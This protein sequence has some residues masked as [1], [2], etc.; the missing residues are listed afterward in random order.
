MLPTICPSLFFSWL[1][2]SNRTR[3]WFAIPIFQLSLSLL[4]LLP[5]AGVALAQA[6]PTAGV[7]MFST[8]MDGV[9]LAT[10]NINI[11][12]PLLSKIGKIPFSSALT[13]TSGIVPFSNG[14]S[15][16][17]HPMLSDSNNFHLG[18]PAA[19]YPSAGGTY[20][21]IEEHDPPVNCTNN[22]ALQ[23]YEVTGISVVDPGLTTHGIAGPLFETGGCNQTPSAGPWSADDGS[24]YTVTVTNGLPT[25]YDKFG[26]YTVTTSCSIAKSAPYCVGTTISDPDGASISATASSAFT[27][28]DTL[29][30]TAATYTLGSNGIAS[31]YYTADNNT[32][33]YTFSYTTINAYT[34]FGCPAINDIVSGTYSLLTGITTP[35]GATYSF[36][37]EQTPGQGSGYTTGRIAKITF[38]AG[39][40]ISYGYSQGSDTNGSNGMDCT[41]YVVPKLIVTVN[42]N[43]GNSGVWTYVNTDTTKTPG[44]YTVTETDPAGNQTTY[45][46]SGEYQT[47]AIYYQGTS[48]VLK[49]VLTCYNGNTSNCAAP[50]TAV[51]LPIT[52]TDVRTTLG[53]SAA[54][55]LTTTFDSYG[56]TLV[57]SAYDFG[58]TL[59]SPSGTLLSTTT[60]VY[61]QS[62]SSPTAC[63]AYPSG[64]YI[65]NTPCYSYTTN[66]AGTKV[67]QTKIAY[68]PTGH[69]TQVQKWTSGSN[70]LTSSATYNTT[71]GT[72]ATATDVNGTVSTYSYSGSGGCENSLLPTSVTVTG[73]NLPSAGLTTSAQWNC[74]G[75]VPIQTTDANG[76]NTTYTYNDPLWRVK[77][78]TD[79]LGFLTTYNY[80]PTT[81]E[82][83]MN[84]N[85]G[86]STTE[87]L[88]T[89]DGLGRPIYSQTLQAPGSL[90]YDSTQ[91]TYSWTTKTGSLCT[92]AGLCTTVSMSYVGTAGQAAPSGTPVTTTQNDALGRPV[93]ITD[94]GGGTV[95]YV[96]PF[97]D[98]WESVGPGQNFAKQFQYDSMGRLSSVC[99]IISASGSGYG[100]CGQ[101]NAENGFLTTYAYDALGDLTNVNQNMQS[102]AVNGQ[103]SRTYVYDGL[104][105]LT[106]ETN[107]ETGT[108]SYIYDSYPSGTCGG[109]TSEPGE[110][111]VS[112][113]AN[114]DWSCMWTTVCIG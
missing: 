74:N 105:R 93:T 29:G 44:N 37:Y 103:Q 109:W 85:D 36:S 114:G 101:S 14:S 65:Y 16:Y 63:N 31:F 84:F 48:T 25:I 81:F 106:S 30:T 76:N 1:F 60:N 3:D 57:V 79:P 56:N 8:N 97:N 26:N 102:G 2:S 110:L 42:D 64:T 55:R 72:I 50:T 54:S 39:G 78:M 92:G 20:V 100:P 49:T 38:P 73:Y 43:N 68:S 51:S 32:Q 112:A 17:W 108:A 5:L 34:A 27:I 4:L 21:V 107:P 23:S 67:A 69:P 95:N 87:K 83:V 71:Y 86:V 47:E 28:T 33:N 77:S 53:T 104:S 96:Y 61:G 99:E 70:W 59:I 82:S 75:G 10:S 111:M 94:G 12:I 91:T 58:G 6:D 45:Y 80:S 98:V 62:Y 13:G 88:I 18:L 11:S 24:G 89:T 35:T 7:Q 66:A 15:A 90:N 40:S 9:D 46:F 41:S 113:R 19:V 52:E 22:P